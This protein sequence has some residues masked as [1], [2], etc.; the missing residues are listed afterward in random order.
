MEVGFTGKEAYRQH[1]SPKDYLSMHLPFGSGSAPGCEALF[2]FVLEKLHQAFL[3]SGIQGDTLIDIGSGPSIYQLLSACES[4]K[5]IIASDF[6]EQN[7]EEMQKWLKKDPEAFD[8]S[9]IVKYVCQLEGNREKWVEKEEK[10]RRT[11]KQVLKCDVTLANPFHP[12]VVPPADCVLS[13][14]CLEA[15]CQD[16]PTYRS[17]VRN[18]GSLVKPGGHLVFAVVT[19]ETFYMVGPH[20]FSCLYLTK[21]RVEEAVKEAGFCIRWFEMVEAHLPP[22]ITDVHHVAVLVAQKQ[23]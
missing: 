1:F 7:R 10:L 9:P 5:E 8:W 3:P 12:L 21:D 2:S 11:V 17:A 19:E 18:V 15:A 20:R 14:L 22:E 23:H 4:F 13:T 16:L 6:L